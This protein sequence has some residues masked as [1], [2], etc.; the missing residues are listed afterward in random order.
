VC[1]RYTLARPDPDDL[2][3]RFA[4]GAE[5]V[6]RRR[7]NVAPGDDVLTVVAGRDGT[8][9]GQV[10]RWGLVPRWATD[11]KAGA[12]MINAR[13]E[14]IA[15]RPAFRDA[16]AVRRCLVLA[17]G[18]YEWERPI[19]GGKRAWWITRADGQPFAFAGVWSAWRPPERDDVEPL[20]TCAIVTT[21]PNARVAA[22][23]D[24]MPV[25]L[26]PAAEDAWLD[27]STTARALHGLLAPLPEAQTAARRVGS[28]VDDARHDERDCL[29]P[30][31]PAPEPAPTLF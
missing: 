26:P 29:D 9:R 30:P 8:P 7:F 4:I 21:A 15:T 14:T 2:R 24:R 1:G 12:R 25:I 11:P 19:G 10:L 17:D 6:V 3:A 28:A 13:A 27:P 16:F 5:V 23:H 31:A 20:V 22:L 18:F